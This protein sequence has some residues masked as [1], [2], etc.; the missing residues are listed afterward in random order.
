[1]SVPRKQLSRSAKIFLFPQRGLA[2]AGDSTSRPTQ[3]LTPAAKRARQNFRARDAIHKANDKTIQAVIAVCS[4]SE[5]AKVIPIRKDSPQVAHVTR[6][7]KARRVVGITAGETLID[8]VLAL[9]NAEPDLVEFCLNLLSIDGPNLE[10]AKR[11]MGITPKI[12]AALLSNLV[13]ID[14]RVDPTEQIKF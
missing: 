6:C 3:I 7:L 10:L 8:T 2:T 13:E 12:A 11:S 9:G 4:K 5:P 1:M 14:A